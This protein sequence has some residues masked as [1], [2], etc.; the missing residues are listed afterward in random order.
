MP[1]LDLRPIDTISVLT[2]STKPDSPH[3]CDRYLIALAV[4][5]E[6]RACPFPDTFVMSADCWLES[7][8][9][10]TLIGRD[11]LDECFFQYMGPERRFTL[12][13]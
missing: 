12:A 5:A 1:R 10:E 6:G 2:P 8:G 4:V 7:E 11:I 13:L 9:I 3:V